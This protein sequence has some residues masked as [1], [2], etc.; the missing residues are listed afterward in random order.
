M[1]EAVQMELA[2]LQHDNDNDIN[3]ID[4]MVNENSNALGLL[5]EEVI[6]LREDADHLLQ[7]PV[8]LPNHDRFYYQTTIGIFIGRIGMMRLTKPDASV[9]SGQISFT[10]WNHTVSINRP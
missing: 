2:K 1:L 3:K 10:F 7:I 9:P 5:S 8:L 4:D 6:S